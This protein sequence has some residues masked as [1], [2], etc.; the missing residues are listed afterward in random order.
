MKRQIAVVLFLILLSGVAFAGNIIDLA[1]RW[2]FALDRDDVGIKEDWCRQELKENIRLPG[3]LPEQGIGDPVSLKT[4]WTGGIVDKSFF[5]APEYEKYRQPGNIKVPFWL[6]PDTYYVGAAWYQR[7]F[8]VPESWKG[9]RVDLYI[10]LAHWET[11]L[12]VD[13]RFFGTNNALATPHVYNLGS[14]VSGKHQL[15]V[16][17]NNRMV[18]DVGHDSHSVS[19]HT[20][21]NWNG[22][23]GAL[24]LRAR[25][26]VW[27]DDVQAYPDIA[28][29]SA[30]VKV[31]IGNATGK[32][33]TGVLNIGSK[34]VQ[35]TWREDG[36]QAEV[37]VDMSDAKLWDEFSPNL[38]EI[39]VRLGED[40]RVISFGMREIGS[41]GTQFTINGRPVFFRGTLEC[42]IFP[43][44]G[45][46]PTDV[47]SWK[48]IIRICQAHGLNHLRFHSWC[49]PEAAFI[50]ADEL[51][52]YYAVECSSWGSLGNGRPLDRWI[53][54]EADRILKF[55][56]NHPSLVL[57]AYGNE[58]GGKHKEFLAKWVNHYK[59]EDARRLYTSASGWPQIPENQYHVTPDPRI[60]GWGQGLKSR[61]NSR[62]PETR[63]DYRDYI[64][65]RNVPVISHEIGQWCVYPDF[66]EIRKYTGYLKPKNF[67]IFRD[68]LKAHHMGDQ[69]KDF[70]LASGKLQ[71]LCY[72][73]DIESALRTP[74]MGGFQLLDLHDFPGQGTALVGVLDPFW[75]S[76]G[77]VTP[78]EYRRFCNSTVPLTRMDKRVFTTGEK[79]EADI[80][81]AHFGAAPLK[82]AVF[83]WKLVNDAGKV[84]DNGKFA[85]RDIPVDNGTS[86]GKVCVD[87]QKMPAPFH[88]K[89]V[90]GLEN[91]KIENDWDVWIYPS[92]VDATVPGGI[93]VVKELN[94]AA[95]D[96]LKNGGRVLLTIP[97]A[98]VAPDSKGRKVAIGFSSIFWNTAWTRGQA[99]H[100]L[101]I[102]C[103]PKHPAFAGFPTEFCSNW[104]WWYLVNSAGAM[105][106]D[107]MPSE[108]HPVV[109]VIDDWFTA[110]RLGLAFEAKIGKGSLLVTSVDLEKDNPVTRQFRR[111]FLDYM[112]SGKFNPKVQV[113]PED[114]AKL[115]VAPAK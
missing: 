7:E 33:G 82:A 27:I 74:G 46:P 80:E 35:A 23:V 34:A 87:L 16:R 57:M 12:W 1:G 77:Y 98:N 101:G 39:K 88:G 2:R 68:L 32:A 86:V 69:A 40:N 109:Q 78:E 49:P 94:P 62:P 48:R 72:K 8:E 38:T 11:Q 66:E 104:Q 54:E 103:E 59:A 70:L 114:I 105:I 65:K 37:N 36:G 76:K 92:N 42:C 61:I 29:K 111:S 26:Q 90:V 102:L 107:D 50:A 28:K 115:V 31:R 13:G 75:E 5:N 45:H 60:Q 113:S 79:L 22:M 112:A 44:T 106:L 64:G 58:P 53:Y 6:Q 47:E 9:K 21:G 15:A 24:E 20:Q 14:L 51:G 3:S 95:L 41:K 18:V 97:P 43:K 85:A 25:P 93:T 84:L 56:G 55:Y 67:E 91:A 108:L 30:L 110:R 96:V 52:F 10:E 19:D 81:V 4:P 100:T 73:E 63:T 99:P 17:V 71:T 89:L 83:A